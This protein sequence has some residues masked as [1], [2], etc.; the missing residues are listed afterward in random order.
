MERDEVRL[1]VREPRISVLRGLCSPFMSVQCVASSGD[2]F[3]SPVFHI[4]K[5]IE[6]PIYINAVL[7]TWL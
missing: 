2:I 4:K 7:F 6:K 3:I 1:E 5:V